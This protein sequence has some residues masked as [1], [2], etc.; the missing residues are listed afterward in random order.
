MGS[1]LSNV[2][3]NAAAELGIE[4]RST[5]TAPVTAVAELTIGCLLSLLR[6][7]HEMNISLHQKTWNKIIGRQLAGMVVAVI[8]LG[9]IGTKIA[10][11]LTALDAKVIGVDPAYTGGLNDIPV[12]PI[13]K[14]LEEADVVTLHCSG[15]DKLIGKDELNLMKDGAYIL[16]AARGTLID[17]A[18]LCI[19]LEQGKIA[20]A[21]LDT[22][23]EEPYAGDLASYDQVILTPHIG[24]YTRE[25][26]KSME[27]EAAD[28]LIAVLSQ[29]QNIHHEQ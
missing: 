19:S 8:G 3:L 16:N 6:R 27:L 13:N 1:G 22:F 5:P 4:V 9:N 10:Q 23:E 18:A 7:T 12:Y 26:R 21:W 20:G 14:A 24:S 15:E 2:D 17:E 11:L 29:K 28:N 25:C